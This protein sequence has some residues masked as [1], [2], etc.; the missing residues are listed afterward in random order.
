[1]KNYYDLTSQEKK[2]YENEFKKTP[3]G[4]DMYIEGT[5]LYI[6]TSIMVCLFLYMDFKINSNYSASVMCIAFVINTVYK[7][8]LNINFTAWLKNKYEI[9]RW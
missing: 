7:A 3:V 9:K 4:K 1:M 8:Y 6:I 2:K 5:I